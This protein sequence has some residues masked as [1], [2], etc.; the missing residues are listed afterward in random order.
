M[1]SR[2]TDLISSPGW[3]RDCGLGLQSTKWFLTGM[4]LAKVFILVNIVRIFND[5]CMSEEKI[6]LSIPTWSASVFIILSAI[7]LPWTI[8]LGATL[9][10]HHLSTHWDIIW[11]GLDAAL[12]L[13]LF[14]TG[15]FAYIKSRWIAITSSTVGSLLLVDAWFDV[16]SERRGLQLHEA[17]ILAIFFELPLAFTSYYIAYRVLKTNM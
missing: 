17:I 15:I 6:K 9:P 11:T 4:L 14:T 2:V 1:C 10:T 7:L 3:Y 12:I 13:M 5:I 16:M 8:Y